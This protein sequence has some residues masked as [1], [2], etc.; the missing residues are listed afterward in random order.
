MKS[1]NFFEAFNMIWNYAD[2]TGE[3]ATT[4]FHIV[5][6]SDC[7]DV[8]Q[9]NLD[10]DGCLNAL[11]TVDDPT[12]KL[13]IPLNWTVAGNNS[14]DVVIADDVTLTIGEAHHDLKGVFFTV[15]YQE[16]DY[17]IAYMLL[18]YYL[19]VTNKVTFPKDTVLVSVE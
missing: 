15:D 4:P 12:F 5:L 16:K 3:V 8:F 14:R 7:D 13:D 11:V 18:P 10:S 9:N 6:A 1:D 19:I 17:V 2:M